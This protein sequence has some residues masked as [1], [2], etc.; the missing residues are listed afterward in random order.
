MLCVPTRPGMYQVFVETEDEPPFSFSHPR[1]PS[2]FLEVEYSTEYSVVSPL[3][4]LN[5]AD[6]YTLMVSKSFYFA[7]DSPS[8]AKP[9]PSTLMASSSTLGVQLR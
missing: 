3:Q 1:T 6:R 4:H 9:V 8:T 5:Q 2:L 7:G